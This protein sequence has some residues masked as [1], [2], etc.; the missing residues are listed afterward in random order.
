M[1]VGVDRDPGP[2]TTVVADLS[3]DRGFEAVAD[4]CR[5]LPQSPSILVNNAG[6]GVFGAGIHQAGTEVWDKVIAVNARSVYG[7]TRALL[8][9][10]Q[11]CTDAVVVNV[12][13]VHAL[14]TS[15]GMGAYAASKGAVLALTRSMALDLAQFGIRVVAVLPGAVDTAMLR[16]HLAREGKSMEELGFSRDPTVPGRICAPEEVAEAIAFLCSP[17]ASGLTGSAVVVDAGLLAGY[18]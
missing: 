17:A 13:S 11:A 14:A 12:S 5:S 16:E 2:S 9:S 4:W 7:L 6:I 18:A 8:P 10:L 1:V 15:H 3:T